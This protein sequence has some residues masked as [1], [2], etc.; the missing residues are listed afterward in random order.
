M[1]YFWKVEYLESQ[2]QE[3]LICENPGAHRMWV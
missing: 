2:K 3:K 1:Q